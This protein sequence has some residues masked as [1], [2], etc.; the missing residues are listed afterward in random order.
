M[1]TAAKMIAIV[2][3]LSV[4]W[5]LFWDAGSCVLWTEEDEHEDV[6][7]WALSPEVGLRAQNLRLLFPDRVTRV[8]YKPCFRII[9]CCVALCSGGLI[10]SS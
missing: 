5:M 10:S 4:I 9:L 3:E 2:V 7:V 8:I 1:A 6:I